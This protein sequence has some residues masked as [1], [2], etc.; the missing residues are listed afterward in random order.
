MAIDQQNGDTVDRWNSDRNEME[1]NEAPSVEYQPPTTD[2]LES[3]PQTVE[4]LTQSSTPARRKPTA[5]PE[6]VSSRE[7]FTNPAAPLQVKIPTDLIQSLKLHSIANGKTMSEMVLDCLT[8]PEFLQ[9][10]WI[11][12]RRAA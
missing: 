10:A 3:S 6:P 12:T 8:S 9:K 1:P 11:S 2:P 5:K 7:D 4:D